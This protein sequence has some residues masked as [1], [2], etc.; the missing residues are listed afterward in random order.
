MVDLVTG[1][2]GSVLSV[3][4]KDSAT[5]VVIDL[6][7]ATVKL[8]WEDAAGTI[9]SKTMTVTTPATGIATYQFATTEIFAP[10]MK[11]E[12]EITDSGG[13]IVSNL[14]LI[15]LTVREQLG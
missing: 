1:D 7:G 9:V 8:R 15:E 13:K 10:K 11:F 2:T 12:V 14:A 3:T 4:C 5:G 6:T